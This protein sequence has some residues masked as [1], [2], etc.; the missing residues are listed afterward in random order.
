MLRRRAF[1][2]NPFSFLFART[3]AEDR[4]AQYLIREHR[5]GRSLAE[6]MRDH[7]IENRLGPQ[8]QRRLLERQDVIDAVSNDDLE[9][10]R[11]YVASLSH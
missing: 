5:R 8:Q 9:A 11:S 10:A 2:R 1:L 4:C 6:I 3:A 7:Y